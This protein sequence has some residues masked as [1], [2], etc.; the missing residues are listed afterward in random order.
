M[1]GGALGAILADIKIAHSVFAL[2]F[3]ILGLLV[4]TRG[5]LPDIG[6]AALVLVAM[7]CARSA[8]MGF[9]RLVDRRFDATNPRTAG[10]A[11]PAGRVSPA[12][13]TTFVIVSSAGFLAAAAGLGTLCLALAPVVLAILF[14]YS[15]CKRSTAWAHGV[16]GLALGLAPPAAYL[17][18]RGGVDADVSA[19]LLLALA[20]LCWVAGFDI[21]YACQDIDHDRRE[22]LSALPARWGAD[23]ALAAARWLHLATILLLAA[24]AADVGLGLL[25]GLAVA[26]MAGLLVLEHRLV[27]GGRL[28][29]IP[30]AFFTVNG[31]AGLV[32]AG[33]MGAELLLRADDLWP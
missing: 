32:F 4:G 26:I 29:R 5:R 21:I 16:L 20:V 31:V 19:V 8:A 3:A 12:A 33:L 14:A 13:M 25:S 7:V 10:R 30:A 18:A 23:R 24:A 15:L 9:N 11:L 22:G 6:T 2:P 28:D 27:A 17:A 1:S